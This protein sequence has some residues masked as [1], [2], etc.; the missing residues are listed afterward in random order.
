MS[1]G[2]TGNLSSNNIKSLPAS[3]FIP[4]SNLPI[5]P[6]CR[7]YPTHAPGIET[8]IS[9]RQQEPIICNESAEIKISDT[10]GECHKQLQKAETIP[11]ILTCTGRTKAKVWNT[12]ALAPKDIMHVNF[13]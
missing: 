5:L 3:I 4:S 1:P 8:S 10:D 13:F 6:P 11:L 2:T 9:A 7:S 12:E